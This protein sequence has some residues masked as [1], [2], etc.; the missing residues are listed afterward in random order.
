MTQENCIPIDSAKNNDDCSNLIHNTGT[1]ACIDSDK[2]N[3][4]YLTG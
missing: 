2:N 4:A 3:L 1:E